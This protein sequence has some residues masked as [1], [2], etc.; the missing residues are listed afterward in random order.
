MRLWNAKTGELVT[1][2]RR[3]TNPAEIFDL[4][5][6]V[7]TKYLTVCSSSGTVHI[8]EVGHLLSQQQEQ[9]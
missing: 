1:E 4:R 6:D 5:F 2:F 7:E 9:Q 8:F 3:G